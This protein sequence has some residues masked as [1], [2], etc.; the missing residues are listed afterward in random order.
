MHGEFAAK[1]NISGQACRNI[2]L[3]HDWT[4]I[5]IAL[6]LSNADRHGPRHFARRG[7]HKFR[8]HWIENT[9]AQDSVD[10]GEILLRQGP[11]AHFVDGREL[12]RAT[13]APERYAD[14][15]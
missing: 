5:S 4:S 8:A 9:F 6:A 15:G 11:A 10:V 2:L 1:R 14:T 12:L 7:C 3:I 13:R